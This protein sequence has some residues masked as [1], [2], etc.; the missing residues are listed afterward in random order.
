MPG[1]F[2]PD[3][4]I[5]WV[6]GQP[7]SRRFGDV[8]FSR[9]NGLAESRHVFLD[10]NDL[11]RR[12]GRLP[13]GGLFVIGEIGFGTGLNFLNAW[14][15]FADVAPADARLHFVSTEL[16]PL[17]RA[18]LERSTAIWPELAR[19]AAEFCGACGPM[20][21]GT[22]RVLFADGRVVL[23]LLVG[24]ARETLRTLDARVDAWF[25]DGFAPSRNP[26]LW[27]AALLECVSQRSH[28]AT[29][30]ATY[31]VAGVVRRGLQAV[32]FRTE[33]AP[34][35]GTKREMLRGTCASPLPMPAR[36]PWFARPTLPRAP[37]TAIVI[38]GGL[39]GSGVAAS[40]AARGIAVTVLERHDSLAG[41]A[42]GNPQGVL[43]IKP[44]PHGTALTSL[45]LAG[46]G[47]TAREAARRLPTDG[48]AW[49]RCGV[50]TLAFDPAEARRQ[51]DLAALGWP[52]DFMRP[53]DV[54]AATDIAGVPLPHGGLF[55]PGAGW[56]HPPA[57]CAA[58]LRHA[59]IRIRTGVDAG[60]LA[61][62]PDGRWV[63]RDSHGRDCERADMVVVCTAEATR[64]FAPFA[65]LPLGVIRGQVTQI[66]ATPRSVGLRAVVCGEGY[67]APV[68]DGAHCAG[69]T[70]VIHDADSAI[71]PAEHALN[72]RTLAALA[73]AF[74]DA[75]GVAS[76]DPGTLAG[77]AAL[78]T[79][80]PDY[81]PVVGPACDETAFLERYDGLARDA[82]RQFDGEAPWLPGLFV[83]TAHGSR[84][85]VS[86]PL[87]GELIAAAACGEP[88]PLPSAVIDALSPSR[89]LVR[90]LRRRHGAPRRRQT[91]ET[92]GDTDV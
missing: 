15:L 80:A 42:S 88:M 43:H 45:M 26:E 39:A 30:C 51:A 37:R 77:R 73:P 35:F 78:R 25:L 91:K 7:V 81:L 59:A 13:A 2:S 65:H 66:P 57:L 71:R 22:H 8:Y 69:A 1:T 4:Q 16:H 36:P 29:T 6:E 55:Y 67:V 3:A 17:S 10:G 21:P 38:G 11:P 47:F 44:S 34:G 92:G 76:L 12:F 27:S 74:A 28:V 9:A 58:F 79:V 32:G 60:S 23:T 56:V 50:L 85:L 48:L 33:K 46:V 20:P 41:G 52:A 18:E 87:S 62:A 64:R 89:F 54:S 72:L 61:Q 75:A 31:S 70:F 5:D 84:G 68:R 24:D 90:A 83:S 19:E 49:S 14:R 63:V 53:V 40:L 86:A 82:R